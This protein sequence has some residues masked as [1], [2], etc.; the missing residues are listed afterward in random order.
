MPAG[1]PGRW[2]GMCALAVSCVAAPSTRSTAAAG[3]AGNA[4]THAT[5]VAAKSS[6]PHSTTINVSTVA[7]AKVNTTRATTTAAK[8]PAT[9]SGA[10]V[11]EAVTGATSNST[12]GSTV[13]VETTAAGETTTE[14]VFPGP[15]DDPDQCCTNSECDPHTCA[16]PC[17][18]A[19]AEDDLG[20]GICDSQLECCTNKECEDVE[21]PAPCVTTTTMPTTEPCNSGP[22]CTSY[23]RDGA[24]AICAIPERRKIDKVGQ[25]CCGLIGFTYEANCTAVTVAEATADETTIGETTEAATTPDVDNTTLAPDNTTLAPAI[26]TPSDD[27]TTAGSG[28]EEPT[29]TA[30]AAVTTSDNGSGAAETT[31]AAVS[32]D[33]TPAEPTSPETTPE[34]T[35]GEYDDYFND[36]PIDDFFDDETTSANPTTPAAAAGGNDDTTGAEGLETTANVPN[37]HNDEPVADDGDDAINDTPQT[38]SAVVTTTATPCEVRSSRCKT[39]SGVTG[40]RK[41]CAASPARV[42]N[43]TRVCCGFENFS[44]AVNCTKR[45]R[46]TTKGPDSFDQ[47]I[48][49][50]TGVA[51]PTAS[52]GSSSTFF[53]L[54]VLVVAVVAFVYR[55][56]IKSYVNK[57]G[58][59]YT[60]PEIANQSYERVP[61]MEGHERDD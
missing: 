36:E 14:E 61:M 48:P 38:T 9:G 1:W 40:L 45:S 22:T 11:T 34:A 29:T 52:E 6:T 13:A 25:R 30:H 60:R 4:T 18:T 16:S 21:C 53:L 15:C 20:F 7:T 55:E 5:T 43:V 23:A 10:Q 49:S 50:Q 24:K 17:P 42:R 26:T 12:V 54:F 51:R 37:P 59:G 19:A 2:L 8:S 27:A 44:S 32:G 58:S 3:A 57:G 56:E 46:T 47:Q 33:G 28:A 35:V 31:V 41:L 39:F